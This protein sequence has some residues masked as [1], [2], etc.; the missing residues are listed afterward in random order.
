MEWA[1]LFIEYF[2]VRIEHFEISDYFMGGQLTEYGCIFFLMF[3][4]K[5]FRYFF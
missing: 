3:F 4:I 5:K 1:L 2:M